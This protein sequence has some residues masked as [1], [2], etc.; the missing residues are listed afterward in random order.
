MCSKRSVYV[1]KTS[2]SMISD[3]LEGWAIAWFVRKIECNVETWEYIENVYHSD[4]RTEMKIYSTKAT[5]T[6]HLALPSSPAG[7]L[8]SLF[9]PLQSHCWFRRFVCMSV[10]LFPLTFSLSLARSAISN[11]FTTELKLVHFHWFYI[12]AVPYYSNLFVQ[13]E[14]FNIHLFNN[15]FS[16]FCVFIFTF[17]FSRFTRRSMWICPL[18]W[19]SLVIENDV[20]DFVCLAVR[21]DVYLLYPDYLPFDLRKTP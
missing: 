10:A 20:W 9:S 5:S 7:N 21:L 2:N 15:S 13:F 19:K 12:N 8:F 6:Q 17:L 3:A 16:F 11:A 18:S 14:Q 4:H 1:E